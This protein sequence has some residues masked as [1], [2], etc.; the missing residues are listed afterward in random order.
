LTRQWWRNWCLACEK[1]QNGLL[2]NNE[3]SSLT[4]L[5]VINGYKI[6]GMIILAHP[7]TRR[8]A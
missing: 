5:F 1:R 2:I 4:F 7:S 3:R 8:S 6:N